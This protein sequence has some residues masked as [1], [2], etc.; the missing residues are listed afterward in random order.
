MRVGSVSVALG[1]F[2]ALGGSML[3]WVARDAVS[4]GSADGGDIAQ[5]AHIPLVS[6]GIPRR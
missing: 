6:R 2:V 3:V 4:A 5:V 1:A